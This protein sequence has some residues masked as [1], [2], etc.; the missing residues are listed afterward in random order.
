MVGEVPHPNS[1][2]LGLA[3]LNG[4]NGVLPRAVLPRRIR[5]HILGVVF[6]ERLQEFLPNLV[7]FA[8]FDDKNKQQ[9]TTTATLQWLYSLL[10]QF[11]NF[12]FCRLGLPNP[13]KVVNT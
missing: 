7:R 1:L 11:Y 6:V 12:H 8:T 9:K 13:L 10:W 2:L 3:I 4:R 5:I